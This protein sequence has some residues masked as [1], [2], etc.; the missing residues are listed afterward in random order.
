MMLIGE[1]PRKH[2]ANF[3]R[4]FEKTFIGEIPLLNAAH[5]KLTNA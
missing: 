5:A 2:I 4:D 3:S 1:D